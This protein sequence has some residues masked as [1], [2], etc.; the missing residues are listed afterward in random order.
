MLLISNPQERHWQCLVKEV[1]S[2]LGELE[3]TGEK[4]WQEHIRRQSYTLI[5]IDASL[6]INP[7]Y[8]VRQL[9]ISQPA[10]KIVVMTDAPTW[11]QARELFYAGAADYLLKLSSPQELLAAFREVLARQVMPA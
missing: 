9:R 10:A 7:V 11:K 2:P 5:I 8:I 3:I 4:D 1:L 6:A